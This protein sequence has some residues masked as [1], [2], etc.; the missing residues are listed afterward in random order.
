M[1]RVTPMRCSWM[2]IVTPVVVIIVALAIAAVFTVKQV[3]A[4]GGG[5]VI[6]FTSPSSFINPLLASSDTDVAVSSVLFPQLLTRTASGTLAPDLASTWTVSNHGR[7]YTFVIKPGFTWQS[8]HPITAYD[9]AYSFRLLASSSFP[10]HDNNWTG[11]HVTTP[12]ANTLVV[13]LPE[14]DFTFAQ[15]ATVGI[16]PNHFGESRWPVS[17]TAMRLSTVTPIGLELT[18]ADSNSTTS[19]LIGRFTFLTQPKPFKQ[20]ELTCQSNLSPVKG[21]SAI[22][23]TRLLG[24][25]FNLHTI[26]QYPVRHALLVALARSRSPAL[27]R[28]SSPTPIWPSAFSGSSAQNST[29]TGVPSP[30]LNSIAHTLA[31]E[32]PVATIMRQ[33][34][35]RM[36]KGSWQKRHTPVLIHLV[37]ATDANQTAF[38]SAISTAWR[39]AGFVVTVSQSSFPSLIRTR[40]YPE[41]FSATVV[42]W[43]F[44][45]PDYRPGALW[46]R[47]APL[48]FGRE[49][50]QVVNK[51]SD[52][53]PYS[54]SSSARNSLRV[55][56]GQ[57]LISDA[58][59]IGLAP[60]TYLCSV[61]LDLRGYTPPALVSDSGGL[62]ARWQNWYLKTKFVFKNPF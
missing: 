20:H 21:P 8:G 55:Q 47:G 9:A 58:D 45:S 3:P 42:E 18:S 14:T 11:V 4:A 2:A 28:L 12:N 31:E 23:T 33:A 29:S 40:L 46:G 36:R 30:T 62:M 10:T 59:A 48:N 43:D 34:G 35:Y 16:V 57:R 7:T 41:S 17:S 51:L 54:P 22:P 6:D 56:I 61:P 15:Q 24:L 44:E 13:R 49:D 25:E 39:R 52:E 5:L 27:A 1:R 32:K 38:L 19:N 50:D 60:E 26:P 53:V 37:A